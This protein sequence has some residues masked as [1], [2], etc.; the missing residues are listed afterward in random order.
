MFDSQ[1]DFGALLDLKWGLEGAQF[2]GGGTG[3]MGRDY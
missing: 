2:F 1:H 3:A